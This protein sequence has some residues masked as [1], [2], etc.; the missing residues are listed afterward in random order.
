MPGDA[1]ALDP[2]VRYRAVGEEGVVVNV[3]HDRVLVVNALGLRTLELIRAT[4]SRGATL[5]ALVTE[6]DATPERIEEDLERFLAEL[7]E[8]RILAQDAAG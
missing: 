6:Y 5:A 1:L 2:H 7:R 8:H 3:E 4:G